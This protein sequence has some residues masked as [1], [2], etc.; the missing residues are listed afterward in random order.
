MQRPGYTLTQL[1]IPRQCISEKL[2]LY[3][4]DRVVI[5]ETRTS[6]SAGRIVY[7]I[8]WAL[9]ILVVGGKSEIRIIRSIRGIQNRLRELFIQPRT[10]S[11]LLDVCDVAAIT[12]WSPGRLI[13]QTS[14]IRHGNIRIVWSIRRRRQRRN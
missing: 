4:I 9:R 8:D 6:D 13:K 10:Q 14:N 1:R 11:N 7:R 2:F 5:S 3:R 12:N